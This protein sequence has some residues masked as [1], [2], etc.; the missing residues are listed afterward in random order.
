VGRLK[1][2][3]IHSSEAIVLRKTDYRDADRVVTF[4]T[5]DSGKLAGLV[6]GAKRIRSRFG[7]SLEVLTYGRLIF[8]ERQ[9][10]NLVSVNEFDPIK[11]FQEIREDI[12]RSCSAQYLAEV[13][14]QF[15]PE[16]EAARE[17]FGLLLQALKKIAIS[18]NADAI[19]RIFEIRFLTLI[20]FAPRLD[21]CVLCGQR[22]TRAGFSVREG[23]IVCTGCRQGQGKLYPMSDGCLFFWSQ[24]LTMNLDRMDRV[25][26]EGQLA[27]ELKDLLHRYFV[28]LAGR[29]IRSYAF[30]E[31]VTKNLLGLTPRFGHSG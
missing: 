30:L 10:K 23:G 25:R 29:E 5:R 19:L 17:V 27:R 22:K 26:L 8:F 15:I 6:K 14:L 20:G 4:L 7:A 31:T 16:R 12:L 28:H 18:K 9:T 21:A 1:S 13:I 2:M 11:P 24:A 3:P